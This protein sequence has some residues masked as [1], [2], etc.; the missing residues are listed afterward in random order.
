MAHIGGLVI[1]LHSLVDIL[2]DPIDTCVMAELMM[3]TMMTRMM[4]M[5]MVVVVAVV[6]VLRDESACY[7]VVNY[8]LPLK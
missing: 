5:I 2:G 1:V 6:M 8:Y 7:A 3:V 4:V